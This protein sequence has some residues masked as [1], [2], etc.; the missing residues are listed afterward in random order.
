[1]KEKQNEHVL[2]NVSSSPRVIKVIKS[3]ELK[4]DGTYIMHRENEKCL[5]I[6]VEKPRGKRQRGRARRSWKDEVE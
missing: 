6:L 5:E 2:R 3:K 1:M 4:M